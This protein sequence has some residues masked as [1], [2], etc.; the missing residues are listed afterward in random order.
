VIAK[1][2]PPFCRGLVANCSRSARQDTQSGCWPDVRQATLR[3]LGAIRGL[4]PLASVLVLRLSASDTHRMREP[5][6]R[7]C[8]KR[9]V[10]PWLPQSSPC[11]VAC[12]ARDSGLEELPVN[13]VQDEGQHDRTPLLDCVMV[14]RLCFGTISRPTENGFANARGVGSS[15]QSSGARA[16]VI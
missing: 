8:S 6:K 15:D 3:G 14:S 9:R 4:A 11:P 10:V 1:R 2:P 12:R 5:G 7:R 16:P 13:R